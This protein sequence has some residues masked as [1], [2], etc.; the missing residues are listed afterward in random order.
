MFTGI[1]EVDWAS[2]RHAHGSAEDVP[3]LLRGLTSADPAERGTAL[4]E[5]YGSLHHQ[6]RV[7]DATLAC[8]PFLL[9]LAAH[10]GVP[11]RAGLVDLLVSIGDGDRADGRGDGDGAGAVRAGAEVFV[12]LTTDPDPG[13]RRAAA[14]AVVRFLDDPARALAVVRERLTAEREDG[15]L[16]GLIEALGLVVRRRPAVAGEALDLLAAQSAPPYGPAP[17]LAALAQL[18]GCAPEHVP[19]DLVATALRLLRERSAQRARVSHAP[20]RPGGDSLV[21]RLHGAHPSDEEG[22][23]LLRTLHAALDD[24]LAERTALLEGQLGCPDPTDRCHA[25]WMA[26]ALVRG[27]RGDHTATVRRVG[28]QLAE[29]EGRLRDAA[30][31][32]LRTLF[33]LAAPAADHLHALVGARPDLWVQHWRGPGPVLGAPL[34]ALARTGDAR[35]VPVLAEVLSLPEPPRDA[36]SAVLCLGR[37]GAPLVPALRHALGRVPLDR[38]GAVERAAPLVRAL[39]ALRAAEAVPELVRL[40]GGRG[41]GPGARL[42]EVALEALEGIGPPAREAVPVLRAALGGEH[43]GAAAAAL[44][45]VE[46]DA[47]AVLPVLREDLAAGDARRRTVAA[48]RLARLGPAAGAALPALRGLAVDGHGARDGQHGR[49]LRDAEER[50]AAAGAVC[51]ITGGTEEVARPLRELW[52]AHPPVRRAVAACLADLGPA[53][54]PLRDL[55][56]TELARLRRHTARTYG[57]GSHDVPYDEELLRLCR[58]VVEGA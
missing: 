26:A 41:G 56:A 23:R 37:A 52:T 29:G 20:V 27:W 33:A 7:Y 21:D 45:A 48:R 57:Y 10:E 13:V 53:A 4:D 5:L 22:A 6:G 2:L 46:R 51:S 38:P 19:P 50:A 3:G 34:D 8:V 28:E 39:G 16:I 1:H 42:T 43:A 17:R 32:V 35:A 14:G 24:R 30:V 18:T 15:V 49:G 11:E 54:A 58:V 44:W 9:R 25:V 40:V 12:R 31:S 55:A 47:P 36:G